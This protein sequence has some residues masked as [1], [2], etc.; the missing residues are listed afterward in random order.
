MNHSFLNRIASFSNLPHDEESVVDGPH[1]NFV[2]LLHIFILM[3]ETKSEE[4]S[5]LGNVNKR[6]FTTAVNPIEIFNFELFEC[7]FE[8]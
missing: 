6:A 2:F 5:I 4:K 3:L 8:R 1:Q 7:Y